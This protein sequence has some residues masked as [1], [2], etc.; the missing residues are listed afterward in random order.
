L[1]CAGAFAQA[2]P[3][4]DFKKDVQPLL[5]Q[6]CIG[7]HGPSQQMNGFRLDRRSTAMKGV[8]SRIRIVPG[9]SEISR[10]YLR[11]IATNGTMPP[12]GRLSDADTTVFKN[13]I[14]QGA[15]W[16]DDVA[17]DIPTPPIDPAAVRLMNALREG[18]DVAFKSQL[19]GNPASAGARGVGGS[20]PL[21]YAAL[22]GNAEAVRLLLANGA[23]PNTANNEGTT[24]LMWAVDSIDKV[25]LL[26]DGGAH[27]NARA[28]DERTSL[29]VAAGRRGSTDV[30]KLLLDRGADASLAAGRTTALILA[31][32]TGDPASMRL[33]LAHGANLKADA[34]AAL[35]DAVRA[36]C[37][38]CVDLVAG[39]AGQ[40]ALAESVVAQAQFGKI[41]AV[42][43]LLKRGANVNGRTAAGLTPLLAACDTDA[44]SAEVVQLLLSSGAD[45]S[46][47]TADGKT[48]LI[49]ARRRNNKIV[50]DLLLK[51]GT[52][53]SPPVSTSVIPPVAVH[54][55]YSVQAAVEKSL[56]LLQNSDAMFGRKSG[57]VSCHNNSLTAMT[58]GAAREAGYAVDEQI[59]LEQL[60][61][62]GRYA[63]VWRE[64]LLRGGFNGGQDAASYTLVGMAA[65]GYQPD[66]ATDA[67]SYFIKGM[68]MPDG[69][70]R[71]I[72]SR[73]PIE[74]SDITTTANSIRALRAFAPRRD[75]AEYETAVQRAAAWLALAETYG[76]EERAF[77]LLGL[78]WTG[79]DLHRQSLK[80]LATAL[81]AEQLSDGGWAPLPGMQSNAYATGQALVALHEAGALSAN[82]AAYK[83]GVQYL[84]QTQLED[85]SWHVMTRATPAQPYFES[86]FPHGKDQFI[87]IAA[88]NWA[89]MALILAIPN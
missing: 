76:T 45:V 65:A 28:D 30:V 11:L 73:P 63:E 50:I 85:G 26:L 31:A 54:T 46:A 2:G 59:A 86:G 6:Y 41:D 53:E 83:R 32:R 9:N 14:D 43:L 40:K 3:K 39:A 25:R 20:T 18:D 84:L 79:M 51:A 55:N 62:S 48:A 78:K 77:Q 64:T 44:P 66:A 36:A 58:V 23:A 1:C 33:L 37:T 13:W 17:G 7:C 4:V 38:A 27:V 21:M 56:P 72:S 52:P 34:V 22:Y 42:K 74:Y 8:G 88:T 89:T 24:A 75:E 68:Q 12:S 81:L 57:C 67:L 15:E 80:N 19:S 69:Q 60:E 29:I 70:W 35:D 16:P 71:A 87:S 82:E 49:L 47:R 10:F 5:K 61:W